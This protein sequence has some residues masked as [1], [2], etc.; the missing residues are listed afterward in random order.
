MEEHRS[1]RNTFPRHMR[2]G[3]RADFARAYEGQVRRA[4]GPLLIFAVPN[5]LAHPRLGLSVARRV[6]SAIRRNRI[7]RRLREA[8]RLARH[9]LPGGYD[10]VIVV[11]PH[12]PLPM[13]EYGQLLR[14]A[15]T[16]LDAR[17]R[18]RLKESP[19]VTAE[20]SDGGCG[21]TGGDT[22]DGASPNP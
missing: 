21:H 20:G 4:V 5:G 8:F 13:R 2:L 11:R 3:H 6:G 10:L 9:E 19:G 18:K 16:W 1:R 12:A 15:T 14:T 17:W 22:S 7:K